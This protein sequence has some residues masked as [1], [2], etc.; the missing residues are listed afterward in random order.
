MKTLRAGATMIWLSPKEPMKTRR[1]PLIKWTRLQLRP[2]TTAVYLFDVKYID[3]LWVEDNVAFDR[4]ESFT[5]RAH[6]ACEEKSTLRGTQ[7]PARL[8]CQKP[9]LEEGSITEE[10]RVN[11][12]DPS[13]PYLRL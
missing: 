1:V 2:A 11:A 5:S 13:I 4:K 10:A 7:A 3:E 8:K 12:S 9:I 6:L